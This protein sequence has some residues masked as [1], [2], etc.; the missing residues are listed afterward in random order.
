M[1][2]NS[3][4]QKQNKLNKTNKFLFDLHNFDLP[5]VEEVEEEVVEEIEVEPPPPTFSEDELDAAKAIAHSKGR[6]EGIQ[7]ERAKREQFTADTLHNISEHFATLFAAEIYREKQYEEE[8]LR[9]ALEIISLLAPSLNTRLGEEAL[10]ASL[11]EVLKSQSEQSEIRIELHPETVT[12]IDALIEKI[13]PDKDNAPRYKVV[14]DS[15]LEK[16]ACALSWKD[17][18]MI[19]DP[20]KTANDIK[21]AIEGLLVEQVMAKTNSPLTGDENNAIKNQQAS[22][23]SSPLEDTDDDTEMTN[24]G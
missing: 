24:D 17:G 16:G 5:E 23:S 22:E 15:N 13:W 2:Q 3:D 19:R 10:K 7:E 4:E 1:N 14:A 8:S 18:G 9:L 6:D 21:T 12:D 20:K 11:Q